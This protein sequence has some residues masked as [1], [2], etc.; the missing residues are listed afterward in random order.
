MSTFSSISSEYQQK[1]SLQQD[2]SKKLWDLLAI[3]K[4][5]S[6]LDLGC[7]PGHLTRKIRDW[8]SGTVFG[9][10]P[11]EGMIAKA[12]RNCQRLPVT[13]VV[14]DAETMEITQQFDVI[15]CNS[16]FQWFV[17]PN[18]ALTNCCRL[19]RP[20]GRMGIQAPARSDYCPNFIEA[21]KALASDPRTAEI[22]S[23][24][25]LP[26]FF[27]DTAEDYGRLFESNGMVPRYCQIETISEP[28]SPEKVLSMFSSGAANGYLNPAYYSVDLPSDYEEVA[29]E[30]VKASFQAQADVSG[31]VQLT[32]HRIYLV[33]EKKGEAPVPKSPSPAM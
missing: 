25:K 18:R 20:G 32:F 26:W 21:S 3:D 2:A 28:C 23:Q 9:V 31:R 13:F 19:L 8:T 17:D 6:V 14:A 12:R 5:E 30:I 29:R 33:A 15:F 22:F 24:F 1:A 16:T 27:L 10:D 7:G 11:A 4:S